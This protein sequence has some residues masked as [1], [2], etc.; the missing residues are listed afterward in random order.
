MPPML[1][2][3]NH[4]VSVK[5]AFLELSEGAPTQVG[6][7]QSVDE[8]RSR[9]RLLRSGWSASPAAAISR[10][11]GSKSNESQR[12]FGDVTSCGRA[13]PA[14]LQATCAKR[15]YHIAGMARH[16]GTTGPP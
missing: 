12:R 6:A 8:M 10:G 9:E 2:L 4:V 1:T 14:S 15:V 7:L 3:D 13:S 5:F 11:C 16:Y